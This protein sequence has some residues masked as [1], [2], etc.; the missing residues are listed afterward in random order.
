[1][2]F[3]NNQSDEA[4]LI[5]D[6]LSEKVTKFKEIKYLLYII[7]NIAE[8]NLNANTFELFSLRNKLIQQLTNPLDRTLA[9][10]KTI[11]HL[12]RLK[13]LPNS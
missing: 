12:E 1:M 4:I 3:D 2:L 11:Q 5:I 10:T 9:R 7:D 8:L 6:Q 13:Q